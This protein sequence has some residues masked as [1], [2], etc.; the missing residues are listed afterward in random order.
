MAFDQ[1]EWRPTKKQERFLSLPLTIFEAFFGGGVG[2]GKSDLL[3]V[4]GIIHRW[5]E[6]PRFKQVFHA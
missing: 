2:G 5:H 4:Y 1:S 6:N 3:L